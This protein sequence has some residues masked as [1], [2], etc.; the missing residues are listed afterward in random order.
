MFSWR[1]VR[2]PRSRSL[3]V[4]FFEDQ[5]AAADDNRISWVALELARYLLE[6]RHTDFD[7]EWQKVTAAWVQCSSPS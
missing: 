6:Q 5:D 2:V 4:N 3:L 7:P 1:Q